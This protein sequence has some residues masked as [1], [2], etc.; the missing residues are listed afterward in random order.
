MDDILIL[1]L[2]IGRYHSNPS[3]ESHL[4]PQVINNEED[5]SLDCICLWSAVSILFPLT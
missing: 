1:K 2:R 5:W 4:E 3:P